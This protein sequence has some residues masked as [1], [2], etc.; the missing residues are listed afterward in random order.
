MAQTVKNLPVIQET[1]IQSLGQEGRLEKGMANHS[2][3]LAWRLPW[4]EEYY[5]PI[6]LK[7]MGFQGVG[8]DNI[9]IIHKENK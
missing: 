6:G 8:H 2:N 5:S 7:S 1:W 9:I 4:T 3:I